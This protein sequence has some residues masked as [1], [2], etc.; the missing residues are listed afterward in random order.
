MLLVLKGDKYNT[1]VPPHDKPL[2]MLVKMDDKECET[3][4]LWTVGTW[5]EK[6]WT[7][8]LD[9]KGYKVKEWFLLPDGEDGLARQL[10]KNMFA[11][12]MADG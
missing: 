12:R 4:L 6:G 3:P 10:Y 9:R 5:G 7:C 8:P 1:G 2:L 11:E